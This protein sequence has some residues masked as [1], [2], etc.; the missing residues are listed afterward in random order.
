M[1]NPL[2]RGNC[3]M[4]PHVALFNLPPIVTCTPTKWCL[5]GRNGKPVCCALR[6]NFLLPNVIL[7][8]QTRLEFSQSEGFVEGMIAAIHKL[9][10]KFF[11]FHAS[12][13][14]YSVAYVR[15][16]ITIAKACPAV[17]FRTTTHRRDL[18][19]PLQELNALPNFIVRESLDSSRPTPK[20]HL[21]VAALSHLPIADDP[22]F[23]RCNND[24]VKCDYSCWKS[25]QSMSFVEH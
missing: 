18:T 10:P 16:V 15:K 8:A 3:K 13:D 23:I 12:G 20:M 4:G 2:I 19:G 21:P 7:G 6:N 24:C 5:H 25:R 1:K 22:L 14:F 11:R 9:G 17:I